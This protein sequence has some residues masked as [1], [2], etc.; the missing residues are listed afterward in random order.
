MQ[1]Y[2]N[3]FNPSTTVRFQTPRSAYV[4]IRLFDVLGREVQT[5]WAQQTPEGRHSFTFVLDGKA[6]SGTYFCRME[7]GS[8]SRTIML[9][10]VR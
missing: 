8:F 1:N 4:V 3:P 9:V 2:P 6:S 10:A 5:L 7:A